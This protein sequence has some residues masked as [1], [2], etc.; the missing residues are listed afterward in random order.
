MEKKFSETT[1]SSGNIHMAD[2]KVFIALHFAQEGAQGRMS[3]INALDVNGNLYKFSFDSLA[4]NYI[5]LET[6]LT[7]F[8]PFLRNWDFVTLSG[9]ELFHSQIFGNDS[10][11]PKVECGWVSGYLGGMNHLFIRTDVCTHLAETAGDL[12]LIDDRNPLGSWIEC[13]RIAIMRGNLDALRD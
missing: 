11:N 3:V 10:H 13:L 9:L 1:V 4:E 2:D 5:Q 8:F 6:L 12:V 7:R